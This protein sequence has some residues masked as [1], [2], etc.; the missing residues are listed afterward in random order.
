MK[1]SVIA[2]TTM[3]GLAAAECYEGFW[4]AD[5]NTREPCAATCEVQ[6]GGKCIL[7]CPEEIDPNFPLLCAATC[8]C[9]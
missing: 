6:N 7:D 8:Q 2:L 1:L 4:Y 3:L 5:R 9:P